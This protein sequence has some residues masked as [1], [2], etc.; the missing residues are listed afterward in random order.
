MLASK[1]T[2]E[3]K[4]EKYITANTKNKTERR[5]VEK[6]QAQQYYLTCRTC[7][8]L[9]SKPNTHTH[10]T[11]TTHITSIPYKEAKCGIFWVEINSSKTFWI[12]LFK[13]WS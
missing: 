3:S 6:L 10:K 13:I 1:R 5:N 4:E 12:I 11:E 9:K 2:Q 8:H 7:Y